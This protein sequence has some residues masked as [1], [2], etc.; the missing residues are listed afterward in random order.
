MN[1]GGR[2]GGWW[3]GDI[4]G[5]TELEEEALIYHCT[6]YVLYLLRETKQYLLD[7]V[8]NCVSYF[9]IAVIFSYDVYACLYCYVPLPRH[10]RTLN[11]NTHSRTHAL[12]HHY[13]ATTLST[14]TPQPVICCTSR[15]RQPM[16]K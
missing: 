11:A 13:H 4:L 10:D 2:L 3:T 5:A 12:T 14:S 16:G 15:Y 1:H 9:L 7:F 8:D 6:Y